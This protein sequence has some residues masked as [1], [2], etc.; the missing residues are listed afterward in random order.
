VFTIGLI[1][2]AGQGR[3]DGGEL[4]GVGACPGFKAQSQHD[5]EYETDRQD[6]KQCL[7]RADSPMGVNR[8]WMAVAAVDRKR[9]R[10]AYT[11]QAAANSMFRLVV[12]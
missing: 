7:H 10:P 3:N 12:A 1:R 2:V 8:R 4:I 5:C 11:Y 6:K 9:D